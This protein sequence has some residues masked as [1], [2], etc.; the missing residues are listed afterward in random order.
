MLRA[1]RPLS[2]L[3]FERKTKQK[4]GLEVIRSKIRVLSRRKCFP[5][6][7]LDCPPPFLTVCLDQF[8][9]NHRKQ[10]T[11]RWVF[12]LRSL[13]E[14]IFSRKLILNA[15][16]RNFHVS[17]YYYFNVVV[18]VGTCSRKFWRPYVLKILTICMIFVLF[19][20]NNLRGVLDISW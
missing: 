7:Q 11:T 20:R 8:T 10:W 18:V 17:V 16:K 5:N 4:S 3:K 2:W 12:V 13:K 14:K 15:Y 19:F 9:Y 6:T 1:N